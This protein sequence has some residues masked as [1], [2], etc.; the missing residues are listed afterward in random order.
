M[1]KR[2]LKYWIITLVAVLACVAYSEHGSVQNVPLGGSETAYGSSKAKSLQPTTRPP[3]MDALKRSRVVGQSRLK[4]GERFDSL[5]DLVN[6]Q[7]L[8]GFVRIGVFGEHWPATVAEIAT[9]RNEITFVR[10]DGVR[11]SY[12]KFPGYKMKMVRLKAGKQET[13]VVFRAQERG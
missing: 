3:T 5:N 6:D 4:A 2:P 13:I 7:L 10:Q 12:T 8:D 1:K 9:D 11:H